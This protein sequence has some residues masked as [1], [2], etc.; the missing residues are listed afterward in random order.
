MDDLF[1]VEDFFVAL[2]VL[3]LGAGFS[4]TVV[5]LERNPSRRT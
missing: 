4:T 3:G 1:V 2:V 5:Q